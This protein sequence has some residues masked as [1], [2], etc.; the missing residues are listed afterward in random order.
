[1]RL[2]RFLNSVHGWKKDRSASQSLTFQR[3]SRIRK[4]VSG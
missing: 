4:A 3:N 1:M 2:F